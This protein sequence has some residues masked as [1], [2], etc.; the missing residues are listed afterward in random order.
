MSET[1]GKPAPLGAEPMTTRL[2]SDEEIRQAIEARRARLAAPA[3]KA[4]EAQAAPAPAGD[5]VQPDRPVQRPPMALLCVLDDG[6]QDGEWV[7]LRADR[8]VIGRAEGDVRVPHDGLMSGRHAEIVRQPAANGYRWL[9]HDLGSTNGSF[10]RV[11]STPLRHDSELLI[12]SG[13]Y[14]FETGGS[15]ALAPPPGDAP[16]QPTQAWSG[17]PVR[18]LAPALVE[19]SPTGPIQ[20]FTLTLPEYWIGRDPSC[21]LA[22]EGGAADSV[23]R[24][25]ARI[26]LSTAGATLTDTGSRN[27]TLLNGQP[28][29][30]PAP[31]R[32]G[33]RIQLGYTGATLKVIDLNVTPTAPAGARPPLPRPVLL[34]AGA[35][36]AL[37]AIP[38]LLVVVLRK[39]PPAPD[40]LGQ[41]E[42]P[43]IRSAPTDKRDSQD[44]GPDN[45]AP[46]D[47][48]ADKAGPEDKTIDNRGPKN[49]EPV[50]QTSEDKELGIYQTREEWGPSVLLQ[51]R[52]PGYSWARLASGDKVFADH[53]LISLPG[54]RSTVALKSGVDLT[55]WGNL[56][57][58][59]GFPPLRESAVVLKDPADADLDL[60]LSRGRIHL[61][62]SKAAGPAKIRLSFFSQVWEITLPDAKSEACV[63]LWSLP[64]A[65]PAP[66][67]ES[68]ASA[69]AHLFVRGQARLKSGDQEL[70]LDDR[71]HIGWATASA[72]PL[73]A[74]TWPELPGWWTKPPDRKGPKVEKAML[75]LVYWSEQLAPRKDGGGALDVIRSRVQATGAADMVGLLFLASLDAVQP[76]VGFLSDRQR[77]EVRG[78]TVH[79]L[80][81]WLSRGPRHAAELVRLLQNAGYS[82]EKARLIVDLLHFFPK[83]SLRA[84]KTYEELAG[85]LD[86]EELVV[87]EL[88]LWHLAELTRAGQIPAK[89][90]EAIRYDPL[91]D[92]G[93]RRSAIEQWKKLITSGKVQAR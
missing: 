59:S 34:A 39:P 37:V 32:A 84:K 89:E 71:G 83:D 27:G 1:P 18:A 9:L 79:A 90:A 38:V 67:R 65:A 23:S 78:A 74:E 26:D 46:K 70:N 10:V 50:E 4:P 51:R 85:H 41:E 62:N 45:S 17:T 40:P 93:Q 43:G 7:R 56:P 16:N 66:G 73:S 60:V 13:R 2:E 36:L 8:T 35:G 5:D 11:G 31:L 75:S 21:E 91:A 92:E 76:L 61:F 63:E 33:D 12:G 49:K 72:A 58:F 14:R 69:E 25:H 19:L 3:R 44:K 86:H 81:G 88:A 57:E 77:S 55:L 87:R 52:G 54:Y 64:W 15:L 47:K 82:R 80:Q 29:Q 42:P 48:R 30:G 6:K 22:L 20:R 28:V 53:A 24:Q 68:G